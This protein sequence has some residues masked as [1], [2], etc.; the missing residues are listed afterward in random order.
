MKKIWYMAFAASML[1]SVPSCSKD[2]D[3]D[4][5]SVNEETEEQKKGEDDG[6]ENSD[7][8]DDVEEDLDIYI[9]D[10]RPYFNVSETYQITVLTKVS[11]VSKVELLD[12]EGNIQNRAITITKKWTAENGNA[13][14]T[15][16]TP[17]VE[18]KYVVKIYSKSGKRSISKDIK[19]EKFSYNNTDNED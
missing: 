17:E 19:V 7:D 3:N 12:S 10:S 4:N 15:M 1:L 11:G 2:E 14:F 16:T 9:K 8:G 6:E 13:V 5:K 18:G